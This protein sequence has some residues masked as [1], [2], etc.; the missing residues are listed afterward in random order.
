MDV[1]IVE[2]LDGDV[3]QWLEARHAVHF[4]PELAQDPAAFAT[5]LALTRAVVI[6][7]ST[8]LDAATLKKAGRLRLVARLAVGTENIDLE[9]CA[10]SGIEV[11]RPASASAAAEAEFVVSALLAMLRRVPIVNPEGLLV[12]RELGACTV[13]LVGMTPAVQPLAKLLT[14]FGARVLGYDPSV[15]ISDALWSRHGIEAVG[16]RE[17]MARSDGVAVLLAFFSRYRGL[18]GDRLF[19]GAKANQVLVSLAHSNLFDEQ[20]LAQALTNG[21]LAAAWM[22]SLEPGVLDVD[23]PLHRVP[24]LQVTPRV[25]GITQSSRLRGAWAVAQRID[26][27][28][29]SGQLPADPPVNASANASVEAPAAAAAAPVLQPAQVLKSARSTSNAGPAGAPGSV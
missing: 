13:G 5:A 3:L 8:A 12:G 25:S 23:R 6:P 24:T 10:R 28:L 7:P 9:A 1:L 29:M 14:A 2:S 15:H 18:F 16:L 22:D 11:V 20:A 19:Q 4:A 21:P 27:M 17:L 26:E